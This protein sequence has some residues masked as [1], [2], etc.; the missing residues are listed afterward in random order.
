MD[1]LVN[2]LEKSMTNKKKPDV[3]KQEV[4]RNEDMIRSGLH[5]IDSL[6]WIEYV[7]LKLTFFFP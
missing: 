1:A 4:D 6:N 2:P 5:A 7:T 3:V